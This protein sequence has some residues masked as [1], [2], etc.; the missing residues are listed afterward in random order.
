MKNRYVPGGSSS[1]VPG[2]L[3][4]SVFVDLWN[5]SGGGG[6]NKIKPETE[7]LVRAGVRCNWRASTESRSPPATKHKSVD[8]GFCSGWLVDW[9]EWLGRVGCS[10]EVRNAVGLV[11][12]K[13]WSLKLS[14]FVGISQ[15][16]CVKC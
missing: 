14:Y 15:L 5:P 7:F 6:E 13:N 16:K 1:G 8:C 10:Y 12:N 3:L 11:W 2:K 4:R 9:P